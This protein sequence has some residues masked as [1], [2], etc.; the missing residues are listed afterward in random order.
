MRVI[1]L[2]VSWV[3][4]KQFGEGLGGE[5]DGKRDLDAVRVCLLPHLTQAVAFACSYPLIAVTYGVGT[6]G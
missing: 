1:D 3:I 2:T 6:Q 4:S 5:D